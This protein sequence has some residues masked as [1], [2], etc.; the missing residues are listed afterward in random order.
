MTVGR[1]P[2]YGTWIRSGRLRRFAAVSGACLALSALAWLSPWFLLFLVPFAVFGY[3][4]LILALTVRRFT[5]RGGDFQRRIHDLMVAKVAPAAPR[6]V[7][8][9]GCGSG[10][11]V[12]RLA[13]A[14]PDSTVTGIDSWGTDWEYSQKQCENNA[15]IEGV[16]ARTAFGRQSAAAIE[17]PDGSFDAV[18]SC[19]TFHE[20]G[21]LADKSDGV[22]EALRVL[23]PGGRYVF[24][25]LFA[26]PACYPSTEDVREAIGRAGASIT[27][28]GILAGSLP[29]PFPLR[30]PKVLGHA[31]LIAGTKPGNASS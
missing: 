25:D 20:I 19:L 12:I 21:D 17:F 6:R 8:D 16:A 2:R 5:P 24:L 18:V 15:R 30:H 7:L 13:K 9:V 29:L 4:T 31:I 3:I 23:R 27:E 22:V 11:L 28:F 26:D 1:A 14:L 10:S